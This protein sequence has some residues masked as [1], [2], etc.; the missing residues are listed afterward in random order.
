MHLIIDV[1]YKILV[2]KKNRLCIFI[3]SKLVR[4]MHTR[5]NK[6]IPNTPNNVILGQ[7]KIMLFILLQLLLSL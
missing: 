7:M 1:V 3:E 4:D 5:T 2:V 6:V